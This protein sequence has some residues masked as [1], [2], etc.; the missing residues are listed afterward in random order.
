MPWSSW[1]KLPVG[2]LIYIPLIPLLPH[3]DDITGNAMS[4][5]REMLESGYG[6]RDEIMN[7]LKGNG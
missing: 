5:G 7:V 1:S 2:M 6:Y 3:N 4:L